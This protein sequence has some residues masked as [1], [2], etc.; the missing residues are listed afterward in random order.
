M[1]FFFSKSKS[2][3]QKQVD[4]LLA[5]VENIS[6]V[7]N[8]NTKFQLILQSPANG[9]KS[10]IQILLPEQFPVKGP[11][12]SVQGPLRHPWIDNYN[13]ITKC[14]SLNRWTNVSS[15]TDVIKEIKLVLETGYN[16]PSNAINSAT[17]LQNQQ[18]QHQHHCFFY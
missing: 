7:D 4:E 3:R 18:H 15:L 11:I 16:G 8:T 12:I 17:E 2:D 10:S 14:V 1:S 13:F 6:R 5:Q 9:Q